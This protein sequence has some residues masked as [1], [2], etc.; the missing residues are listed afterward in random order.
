MKAGSK[1][2]PSLRRWE[3]NVVFMVILFMVGKVAK[4]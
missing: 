4:K 1:K 2:I 3:S